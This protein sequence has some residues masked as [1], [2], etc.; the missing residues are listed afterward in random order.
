VTIGATEIPQTAGAPTADDTQWQQFASAKTAE[1]FCRAWLALLCR[2]LGGVTAGT[3]LL[4]S[5]ET[6]TFVPIAVWPEPVGDL[7]RLAS[8]AQRALTEGQGI[9]QREPGKE[10]GRSNAPAQIA[11][12]LQLMDRTIG[13]VAL[14]IW[15]ADDAKVSAVLRQ[16]H[17]GVAWISDLFHRRELQEAGAKIERIGSVMEGVAT[18][19]R[20]STLQQTLFEVANHLARH[21]RCSRVAIGLTEG[22]SVKVAALSDAAWFEKSSS[23]VKR[24]AAAMEEAFDKRE[25]LTYRRADAGAA[26]GPASSPHAELAQES[27]AT[28]IISMPLL[29]GAACIGVLT[30]ERAEGEDFGD[31]ERAWVQAFAGLLPSII[32][33]KRRAER[34]YW[35]RIED[36]FRKLFGKLLGPRHLVWK[37]GASAALLF[38]ALAV[39][40]EVDYRVSA[41]TVIEGEI[42]RVAAAPFE[43]FIALSHVRAG[44]LV[45]EGQVLAELDDRDLKVERTKWASEKEQHEGKLREAMANRELSAIQVIGAQLRQ[46]EA[47]L[48]LASE[49]IKRAKLIAPFDGV[50]VSGDLSQ[51]TGS[52]VEQG[53][54]LFEIA[55]LSSYR[56]ILQVDEREIRHVEVGHKGQLVISCIAGE[57]TP[58]TVVK[59]T[60]VA[61]AQD[62]RNFFRVEAHLEHAPPRLRPGMEGIGKVSVGEQRLWWILTHS[63][64]D[65]LRLTLWT[66]TI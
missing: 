62:G 54:K 28:S 17:W 35:K 8:V 9:V 37:F 31:A 34:G 11:Y 6:N 39:L 18:A 26:A 50:V 58:F 48:A 12:P 52:P 19:L 65:W 1:E 53:K 20:E 49:K 21:L 40:V 5:G 60:P 14:E 59:V 27:A 61:T 64:T 63:F 2:Q 45:K 44:D 56:V 25:M 4:E 7:S 16:L 42:Q 13:A 33:Q 23:V 41:K 36:D 29:L 66:W 43:G 15:V 24:Y 47:Q 38:V 30:L 55:P 32:D 51:L 3:V 22:H 57:P 10:Q 46:A